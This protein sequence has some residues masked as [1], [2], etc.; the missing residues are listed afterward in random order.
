M[1]QRLVPDIDET[2][3]VHDAEALD[4]QA[5][6]LVMD[7]AFNRM[8]HWYSHLIYTYDYQ[9]NILQTNWSD[10]GLR[11]TVLDLVTRSRNHG[12]E[13]LHGDIQ[14][15]AAVLYRMERALAGILTELLLNHVTDE[16]REDP[17]MCRFREVFATGNVTAGTSFATS[18]TSSVD[19]EILRQLEDIGEQERA[20]HRRRA[21]ATNLMMCIAL[22]KPIQILRLMIPHPAK[23]MMELWSNPFEYP[24]WQNHWPWGG[25]SFFPP[26]DPVPPPTEADAAPV[27]SQRAIGP[28]DICPICRGEFQTED[29]EAALPVVWCARCGNNF[30]GACLST[31]LDGAGSCPMCFCLW[32]TGRTG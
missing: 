6:S 9:V 19:M 13:V 29:Q 14:D 10:P 5:L 31:W 3:P 27:A 22:A 7:R 15:W 17:L 25:D 4:H 12:L 30:H 20:R 11:H 26:R 16:E 23:T 32:Q 8:G 21:R 28:D 24:A 2:L 18:S 1:A